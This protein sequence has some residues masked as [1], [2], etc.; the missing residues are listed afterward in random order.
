[1]AK[2]KHDSDDGDVNAET[3]EPAIKKLKTVDTRSPRDQVFDNP[4]LPGLI[5]EF[6]QPTEKVKFAATD[7]KRQEWLKTHPEATERY[8]C[9]GCTEVFDE[10]LDIAAWENVDGIWRRV[11][12]D[13]FYCGACIPTECDGCH[14]LF[15]NE[16]IETRENEDGYFC[17]DCVKVPCYGCGHYFYDHAINNDNL[18]NDCEN[19][20]D[21]EYV[22]GCGSAASE[23]F[24]GTR[25][26]LPCFTQRAVQ[27][28]RDRCR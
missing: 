3:K 25:M 10:E 13:L 15:A 27:H 14:S 18:C 22:C 20:E 8:K 1:M 7:K 23:S 9:T 24:E 12:D 26:C 11:S 5:D 2:R 4:F 16:D 17:E 6:L 28:C 21:G 19:D